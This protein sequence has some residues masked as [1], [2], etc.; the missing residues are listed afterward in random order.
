MVKNIRKACK[1]SARERLRFP[2][3]EA[4]LKWLPLLLEAYSII[5]AGVQHAINE[6]EKEKTQKRKLACGKGCGNC[7]STHTDIPLYP[8][9]LAGIYWFCTEKMGPPVREALKERLRLNLKAARENQKSCVF[10]E[11]QNGGGSCS[12]HPIRPVSC[13]QFNVFGKRCGPGEDPFFTRRGDVL[14]PIRQYTDR[15]FLVMLPFYG[16]KDEA[17]KAKAVKDGL[18]HTQVMNLPS[19]DWAGLLKVMEE[20][21]SR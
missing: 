6:V 12:I 9:E 21:D 18:I 7:C 2:E 8:L 13:R 3:D 11:I 4:R 10:L 5:D 19:H 16:I 17:Q 15:A 14:T 1:K 20:F